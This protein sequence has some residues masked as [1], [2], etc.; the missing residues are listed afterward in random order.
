MQPLLWKTG[1]HL[2]FLFLNVSM[3]FLPSHF[4]THGVNAVWPVVFNKYKRRRREEERK[5]ERKGGWL[6]NIKTLKQSQEE[7]L[8]G[9][10]GR[11]Q[12]LDIRVCY[13]T[14]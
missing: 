1:R 7:N 12:V 5:E 11:I 9:L 10:S 4:M 13:K 14:Y 6:S 2:L 3:Y 8:V